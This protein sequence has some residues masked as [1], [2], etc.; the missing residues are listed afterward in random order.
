V[1]GYASTSD[2]YRLTDEPPDA[3]GSVQAIMAAVADA[4]IDPSAITY[5]NAHGTGTKMN[6]RTETYAIRTV[7]GDCADSV[8]VSSTKSMIGHLVAAAG[9]IEFITCI[10]ALKHGQVPPTINYEEADDD[11]DLD[12]VP[13]EARSMPLDFILSNSFGFGGQNA[14]LLL[15]APAA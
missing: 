6:D 12:Y 2:A 10:L 9:G 3:R 8:P 13:N 1:I 11:C 5:I 4:G 7:L 14:C 15:K